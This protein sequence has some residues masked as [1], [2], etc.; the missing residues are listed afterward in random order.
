MQEVAGSSECFPKNNECW[1]FNML[2]HLL[3]LPLGSVS[4]VSSP[5]GLALGKLPTRPGLTAQEAVH[6]QRKAGSG[7]LELTLPQLVWFCGC[8][9]FCRLLSLQ[10]SA[11]CDVTPFKPS[12]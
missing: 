11:L 6:H 5:Q 10:K 12:D 9:M 7:F 3:A 1:H 2:N 4:E 8:V